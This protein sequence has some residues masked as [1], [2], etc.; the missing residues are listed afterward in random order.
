MFTAAAGG[1]TADAEGACGQLCSGLAATYLE[2]CTDQQLVLE[3]AQADRASAAAALRC[4][5]AFFP[6]AKVTA[7]AML[8]TF[9]QEGELSSPSVYVMH[10]HFILKPPNCSA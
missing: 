5:L 1:S 9:L 2:V 6:A 8:R 3:N 4:V 7:A 10:A